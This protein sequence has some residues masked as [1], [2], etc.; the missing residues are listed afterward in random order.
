[1]IATYTLNYAAL[2]LT[3]SKLSDLLGRK[4]LFL[5]GLVVFTLASLACGL[6]QDVT[7]LQLAR[8]VQGVGAAMLTPVAGAIIAATFRG[9]KLGTAFGIYGGVS[10]IA[11]ACGSIISGLLVKYVNWQAV[12]FLNVPIG[13]I[14]LVRA[15]TPVDPVPRAALYN[16]AAVT[17]KRRTDRERAKRWRR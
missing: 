4:R 14:G 13:I 15:P 10:V 3:A 7:Q 17:V 12:F 2:I 6:S 1:V 11:L 9:R 8:A 5:A 16:R